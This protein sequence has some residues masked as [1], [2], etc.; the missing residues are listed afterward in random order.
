MGDR[1]PQRRVQIRTVANAQ[2]ESTTAARNAGYT[3]PEGYE[4][5]TSVGA[6][7]PK[8][9]PDYTPP[10]VNTQGGNY[11]GADAYRQ[12]Y[13]QYMNTPTF[14]PVAQ[15]AYGIGGQ[16][17]PYQQAYAGTQFVPSDPNMGVSDKPRGPAAPDT[18]SAIDNMA[19]IYGESANAAERYKGLADNAL[20]DQVLNETWLTME[21]NRLAN[22]AIADQMIAL[23]QD[24]AAL[25][26]DEKLLGLDRSIDDVRGQMSDLDKIT[27][28]YQA[29]IVEPWRKAEAEAAAVTGDN[30][31]GQIAGRIAEIGEGFDLA[32]ENVQAYLDKIGGVPMSQQLAIH[33]SVSELRSPYEGL[34]EMEASIGGRIVDAMGNV[35][36][37]QAAASLTRQTWEAEADRYVTGSNLQRTLAD[38][39]QDRDDI[40]GFRARAMNNAR[41]QAEQNYGGTDQFVSQEEFVMT[42]M[43]SL[44]DDMGLDVYDAQRVDQF[45]QAT[46]SGQNQLFVVRD[47]DGVPIPDAEGYA[48]YLKIES[49]ADLEQAM[50]ALPSALAPD[51]DEAAWIQTAWASY[52]ALTQDWQY[53]NDMAKKGT[54]YNQ[55]GVGH[56]APNNL[57]NRNDPSYLQRKAMASD[58]QGLITSQFNVRSNGMADQMRWEVDPTN[59][60]QAQNSDH[61]SGGALDIWPVNGDMAE[62]QRLYDWLWAQ[63]YTSFVKWQEPGH[64]DHLHVSFLLPDDIGGG[65][66]AGPIYTTQPDT[67]A[68]TQP[69]GSNVSTDAREAL[70]KYLVPN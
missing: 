63:P 14:D 30:I 18:Q 4:A 58:I 37:A 60:D 13:E 7:T 9:G 10:T 46:M 8:Y 19:L 38:M 49:L 16:T 64:Y 62:M 40:V 31:R 47:A 39:E 41:Q 11:P 28:Y 6:A 12:T 70:E 29:S 25:A 69:S 52:E 55:A 42:G 59:K 61:L 26:Y 43:Q 1:I 32:N 5:Y 35:L 65:P 44:Y 67:E 68:T 27:D 51:T 36:E 3:V 21:G 2:A 54:T 22:R 17:S 33:D 23:A 24:Q 57:Q 20:V 66:Y 45:L 48:Q 15:R 50:A 56:Q 53:K 34:S